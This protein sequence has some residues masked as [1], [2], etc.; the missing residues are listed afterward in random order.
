MT[1]QFKD[2]LPLLCYR[3]AHL[4]SGRFCSDQ[5][6]IVVLQSAPWWTNCANSYNV[7]AGFFFP[8]A[9]LLFKFVFT[10]RYKC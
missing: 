3:V 4:P 2:I 7:A 9:S 1:I 6:F 10:G 5:L 8:V